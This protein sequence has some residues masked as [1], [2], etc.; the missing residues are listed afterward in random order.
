MITNN[1]DITS[2]GTN[3]DGL[4]AD[5]TKI[6]PPVLM[7]L[8]QSLI[9]QGLINNPEFIRAAQVQS[10]LLTTGSYRL[11]GSILNELQQA[12]TPESFDFLID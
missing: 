11:L 4:A 2:T 3:P 5:R 7:T 8:A 1:T 10:Q 6:K 9:A 12:T